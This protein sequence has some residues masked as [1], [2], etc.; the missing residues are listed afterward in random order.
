MFWAIGD[1]KDNNTLKQLLA[2]ISDLCITKSNKKK[3]KSLG[4][5]I[6][7]L[8]KP[9][10]TNGLDYLP[11]VEEFVTG[12]IDKKNTTSIHDEESTSLCVERKDK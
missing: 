1:G 2:V 10:N 7:G 11:L 9:N 6:N 4:E 8:I 3:K 5:F 12:G